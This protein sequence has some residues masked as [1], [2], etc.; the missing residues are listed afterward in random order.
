MRTGASGQTLDFFVQEVARL[1][2]EL[3][4]RSAAILDFQQKNKSALPDSL[5][6]RLSQQASAQERQQQLNRDEAALKDRRATLVALF[7]QTG[8]IAP[9]AQALTPA[10]EQLKTLRDQ[11]SQ[12]LAIYTPQNPRVKLLEQQVA[13]QEKVVAGQ[14]ASAAP[15]PAAGAP[16]LTPYDL[17]LA[18]IDAQ[19]KSITEQKTEVA[20]TLASLQT[21]IDATPG[22]AITLASL[23]RDFAAVRAQYD[24]AVKN[25]AQA[26]TG[27]L[28]ETLSKGQR[29][30]II[31][32]AVAPRTP[33]RPNRVAIAAAGIGGGIVL[34]AVLVM[35]LELLNRSI[36]RP[37]EL[38][39]KLG[40]TPFATLPY[41]R[42][43][44]ET[45]R[46][47]AL[48][49]LAL[50]VVLVGIPV[51]LWAMNR[52]YLPVDMVIERGLKKLGLAELAAQTRESLGQ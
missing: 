43:R 52:Y 11:L 30:S 29:F 3:A 42:T 40:I 48:T 46:R 35:L 49:A 28:I 4:V 47:R 6:F 9:P 12:A 8:Q 50:V 24:Q 32:Q 41:V 23:E 5:D 33:A 16:A 51:G 21:T 13:A 22:N 44:A 18:D 17:Q 14:L 27:D 1:D 19:L 7:E 25:K 36:R 26:E 37:A 45:T 34:G 15:A 38:T 2:Q 20:A 10:E 39:R 31:E